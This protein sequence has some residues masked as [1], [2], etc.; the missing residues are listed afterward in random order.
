MKYLLD[1]HTFIW[2]L[3]NNPQLSSKV[4]NIIEDEKNEIYISIVSLWEIAIKLNIQKL[5]LINPLADMISEA[6]AQGFI[7]SSLTLASVL[8]YQNLVRHH[9]DPFDRILISQSITEN[10]PILS[11]D[12]NFDLY[13]ISRIW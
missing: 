5:E 4:K 11:K 10:L 7:L 9:G 8:N 3:E 13:P 1:T 12:V 2:Y 6:D